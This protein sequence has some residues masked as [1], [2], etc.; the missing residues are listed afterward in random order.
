MVVRERIDK[1]RWLVGLYP[2]A[3]KARGTLRYTGLPPRP[4][5]ASGRRARSNAEVGAS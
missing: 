2:D 5:F 3:A 1:A 4:D